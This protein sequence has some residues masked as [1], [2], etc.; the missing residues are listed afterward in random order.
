M[1]VLRRRFLESQIRFYWVLN[2][3]SLLFIA[4]GL[5]FGRNIRLDSDLKS[6]L[7]QKAQSVLHMEEI[8]P[9][10]G[11]S[12]D[13]LL[14]LEGS[15]LNTKIKAAKDFHRFLDE[16]KYPFARS[17]RFQTP[18]D[19]FEKHKYMFIPAEA[20]ENIL[21]RI[22]EKR[23]EHADITDPFGLEAI[24][25]EEEKQPDQASSQDKSQSLEGEDEQLEFAKELLDR[26]ENMKP[27]YQTEDGRFLAIRVVPQLD[28]LD[29]EKNRQVLNEFKNYIQEFNFQKYSPEIQTAVYGSIPRHIQRYDSIVADVSFGGWGILIILLIVTVYFRS[30][31]ACLILVPPL[32][33]GLGLGLGLVAFIEGNLNTIAVFLILVVFGV[34]IEFGIHLWARMLQERRTKNLK[35]SLIATWESTARASLTSAFALLVGFALLIFSSFQGFA[36]FGRVAVILLASTAGSTLIFLPCWIVLVERIRKFKKWKPSLAD[37]IWAI[38]SRPGSILYLK[39]NSV[40][41]VISLI[42]IVCT[43]VT[44]ISF[45]RFNYKFDEGVKIED[46]SPSYEASHKIFNERLKPSAIAVFS[47]LEEA[48]KFL[49][50]YQKNKEK[51]PNIGFMS[52]LSTFYPTDQERRLELLRNISDDLELSW[53]KNWEDEQTRKALIEIKNLAYDYKTYTI[54][55]VPE[56]LKQPFIASDG[57]GDHMVYIF[58]IGGETDGLK[59]MRFVDELQEFFND[60]NMQPIYSGQEVIFADIVSRVTAEGPWLVIGMLVIVFL[61]CWFD[62][63]RFSY[64]AITILPVLFGFLLT[65]FLLVVLKIQINFY[66]MVAL[67]SLG[68][69]VVDN[70]IHMFH[71]YLQLKEK[72]DQDAARRANYAVSPTIITCTMTSICGYGGMMFAKHTG[73]ASLGS[74]AVI[75][76]L[77]C[78]I[79]AVLFFP[80]WLEVLKSP[81][82]S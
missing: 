4:F 10:A 23:K 69:M 49:N 62:F 18:K 5:W 58:D 67:A 59:S 2:I 71:R 65:G 11:G 74:V 22:E 81:T 43:A 3:L 37:Q 76:L 63:R 47:S 60:V 7:P 25:E 40:L 82:R 45:L 52:G 79:C 55:E 9:K 29:I 31:W 51:Y 34:G 48:E 19:F 61:I 42:L 41:R 46:K 80:A 78:L 77:C 38:S 28:S 44:C 33:A 27:Y 36:Q 16:E 26:L 24:I 54:N 13:L 30:V 66:N 17:V 56:E 70:S 1:I 15:D 39:I 20:L 68:S 12:Y 57:S 35:D 14:I 53:I 32:L 8:S 75:G 6:L 21:E 73:I 64:S 50:F 72:G